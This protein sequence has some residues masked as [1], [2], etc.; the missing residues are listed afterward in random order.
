MFVVFGGQAL[1]VISIHGGWL[2]LVLFGFVEVATM[3]EFECVAVCVC[4]RVCLLQARTLHGAGGG[5]KEQYLI[6]VQTVDL[7]LPP[8]IPWRCVYVCFAASYRGGLILE[9][10]VNFFQQV[11]SP[12]M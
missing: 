7:T 9:V 1:V 3:V 5:A 4:M 12:L 11:L 6:D 8:C 10:M 2:M